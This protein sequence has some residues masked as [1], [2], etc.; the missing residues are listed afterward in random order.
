MFV[1]AIVGCVSR[2]GVRSAY[3]R[4]A[5]RSSSEIEFLSVVIPLEDVPCRAWR[6]GARKPTKCSLFAFVRLTKRFSRP[7]RRLCLVAL[8]DQLRR[9]SELS[10]SLARRPSSLR[11]RWT[12]ATSTAQ[13]RHTAGTVPA[14]CTLSGVVVS[15]S[16]LRR[17]RDSSTNACSRRSCVAH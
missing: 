4:R 3:V 9:P 15:V 6:D 13:T 11:S 7:S 14:H 16:L 10:T 12:L 5:G 1:D 8:F 17:S 2:R